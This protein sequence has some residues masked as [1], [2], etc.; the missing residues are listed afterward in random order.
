MSASRICSTPLS[1][2]RQIA[3]ATVAPPNLDS[4]LAARIAPVTNQNVNHE[5][6]HLPFNDKDRISSLPDDLIDRINAYLT[7]PDIARFCLSLR[8]RDPITE[9]IRIHSVVNTVLNIGSLNNAERLLIAAVKQGRHRDTANI[10]Q[11]QYNRQY[12]FNT[13]GVEKLV[14]LLTLSNRANIIKSILDVRRIREESAN[15]ILLESARFNYPRSFEILLKSLPFGDQIIAEVLSIAI[16]NGFT[17]LVSVVHK[18]RPYLLK[19]LHQKATELAITHGHGDTV[20]FLLDLKYPFSYQDIEFREDNP[21]VIR[22]L[23]AENP[24]LDAKP[25]ILE[26]IHSRCPKILQEILNQRPKISTADQEEMIELALDMN[27]NDL[28]LGESDQIYHILTNHF[29]G[30]QCAIQ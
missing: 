5:I 4:P 13:N 21:T 16:F 8:C 15:Y 22:A 11:S 27:E 12:I 7:S 17:H 20:R 23:F 19:A 9:R 25:L 3:Q 24:K 1:D 28:D 6:V 14:H 26:A 30:D 2:T 18:N 29:E 10:I